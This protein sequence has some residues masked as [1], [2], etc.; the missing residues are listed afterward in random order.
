MRLDPT[1][2]SPPHAPHPTLCHWHH[3]HEITF[4]DWDRATTSG[5]RKT[6]H[7]TGACSLAVRSCAHQQG[8]LCSGKTIVVKRC[9][10]TNPNN[11]QIS[12][13][14]GG[15]RAV[16]R[17]GCGGRC[18]PLLKEDRTSPRRSTTIEVQDVV[19]RSATVNI[20]RA[21]PPTKLTALSSFIQ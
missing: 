4:A 2:H 18:A 20:D 1:C 6:T 11:G 15:A 3:A 8:L 13:R 19:V 17:C 9:Q 14:R 10:H 12:E 16:Q 7:A 21:K 5:R